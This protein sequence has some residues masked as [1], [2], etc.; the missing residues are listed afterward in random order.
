MEKRQITRQE[1]VAAA[2]KLGARPGTIT[3]SS[4]LWTQLPLRDEAVASQLGQLPALNSAE[5]AAAQDLYFAPRVDPA[6]LAFLFPDWQCA[7]RHLLYEHD[8]YKRWHYFRRHFALANA[9]RK[10]I[11]RHLAKHVSHHSECHFEALEGTTALVLSQ[12]LSDENTGT[13]WESDAGTPPAVMW[14]PPPSGGAIAALLGLAGTGLLGE[15]LAPQQT[16]GDSTKG[17]AEGAP[18]QDVWREVRGPIEAW[19]HER[20]HTNSPVPTVVPALG[21]SP[22]LN[23][24]VTFNNGYAI[25]NSDGQRLGGAEAIHVRWSGV[26]LVEHEGEY[27]FHAGAPAPDEEKP[28]AERAE[29]S[30]WRITL[31]RGSKTL[32]V[33]NHQ[34]PGETGHEKCAPHLRRGDERFA[35][36]FT[37]IRA[38]DIQAQIIDLYAT[39]RFWPEPLISINPHFERGA[40]I[41]KLAA[42]G[43]VHAIPRGCSGSKVI[44]FG[45]TAIKNRPL[46]KARGIRVLWLLRAR[47]PAS[48]FASSYQ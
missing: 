21:L 25:K 1:L 32:L 38:A 23:P 37:Q 14:T 46:L 9:R 31:A 4:T 45:S 34:W 44:P 16:G 13:P 42:E 7:E 2:L 43:S 35:R 24:L 18:L 6:L 5:Q 41:D 11:V 17:S 20:D 10:V 8:Q 36:S 15:Y 29:R 47:D 28:D 27:R 22:A 3:G 33:L 40:S 12:L 39:N 30:Q 19:G 48:R 26:L